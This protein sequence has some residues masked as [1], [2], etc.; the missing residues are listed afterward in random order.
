MGPSSRWYYMRSCDIAELT[1]EVIDL[2][3]EHSLRIR[4]P[5]TAFPIWQLGGAVARLDEDATPFQGRRGGFTFNITAMTEGA[6]GFDEEREWVR[7]FSS[8]LAPHSTGVYVNFLMDEGEER[9][10]QAYGPRKY[11]RLRALKRRYDPD[12]VL[13]LNQNIVPGPPA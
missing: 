6:E 4:S 10:R 12:N 8:A 9:I 5:L 2:T 13:R 11:E 3:V 1:D 7:D